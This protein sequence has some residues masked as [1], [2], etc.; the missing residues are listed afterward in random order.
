MTGKEFECSCMQC[1]RQ[2]LDSSVWNLL[3]AYTLGTFPATLAQ[4]NVSVALACANVLHALAAQTL[5]GTL[6]V[7]MCLQ[8]DELAGT[9][10][11]EEGRGQERC[12][13][14][15]QVRDLLHYCEG[16]QY[17]EPAGMKRIL[18]QLKLRLKPYQRQALA[19]VMQEEQ[20]SG[21]ARHLFVE[22][23]VP[24][25]PKYDPETR[26]LELIQ[27]EEERRGNRGGMGTC[28]LWVDKLCVD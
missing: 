5:F 2:P 8:A 10:L 22:L 19:A 17:D 15:A 9:G 26:R 24:Q 13:D 21:S 16:Q 25:Q 12:V 18:R 27:Q 23:P 28:R 6:D 7:S 14:L 20:S 4:P 11:Q 3:V 1:P